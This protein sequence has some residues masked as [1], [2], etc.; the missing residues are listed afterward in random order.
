MERSI[1]KPSG[2]GLPSNNNEVKKEENLTVVKAQ[3]LGGYKIL[4]WFSNGKQR[5]IDFEA[6]F[7]KFA[8]GEFRTWILPSNFERFDVSNG[9]IFLG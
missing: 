6:L 9:N 8:K 1:H 4:I 5:I 2:T 3:H 7:L